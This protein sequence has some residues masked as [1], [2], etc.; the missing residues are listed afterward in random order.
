MLSYEPRK[1]NSSQG[2]RL[3]PF[4]LS[5]SNE[6]AKRLSPFGLSHSN[7]NVESKEKPE[8]SVNDFKEKVES[9]EKN[10]KRFSNSWAR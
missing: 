9:N 10:L 3:S 2:K 8:W 5:H 4:G 7:E 1:L 6:N